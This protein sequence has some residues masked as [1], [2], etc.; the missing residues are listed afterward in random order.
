MVKAQNPNKSIVRRPLFT[1]KS[2]NEVIK[3]S[4]NP[5]C[6]E[7]RQLAHFLL[8]V[9]D[10]RDAKFEGVSKPLLLKVLRGW[11][12]YIDKLEENWSTGMPDPGFEYRKNGEPSV[13]SPIQDAVSNFLGLKE[14]RGYKP[15]GMYTLQ[16]LFLECFDR[17]RIEHAPHIFYIQDKVEICLKKFPNLVNYINREGKEECVSEYDNILAFVV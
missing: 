1:K 12:L 8:L 9:I 6:R 14:Y 2:V 16:A 7:L 13:Y 4:T 15:L 11:L 17:K 5:I 3:K 10:T